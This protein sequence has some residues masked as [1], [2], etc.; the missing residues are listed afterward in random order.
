MIDRAE[1]MT[2]AIQFRKELNE[3]GSS[4]ID[5][6]AAA[7]S[8]EGLSIVF[9]PM[10]E[11]LSGMCVKGSGN[12]CTI[13]INSEMTL[14]RQRFSLAHEFYHMRYDNT[15]VS[16]CGKKIG[17]GKQIEKEADLFASYFLMPNDELIRKTELCAAKRPNNKI[18]FD[19]IIRIEQYFGVSHRATVLRLK[20]NKILSWR[21]ADDYLMMSAKSRAKELGFSGELYEP[22]PPKRRYGTYG[23][24]IAQADSLLNRDLIS[25][26]KY[27]SLLLDAF[28]A[29][30]VYGDDGDGDIID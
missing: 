7:G 28:R 4:P 9:Y 16:L 2:K 24:Y 21:E 12:S 5:I 29:D 1:I 3:D 27:E 6:F 13:G 25:E 17:D 14:G 30:L 18:I 10:G 15:T 20:E 26:G 11:K 23:A 22:L 19:D 8:I